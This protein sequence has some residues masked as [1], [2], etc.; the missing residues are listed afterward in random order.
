MVVVTELKNSLWG[1][2]LEAG[3]GKTFELKNDRP[4]VISMA[5]LDTTAT[6]ATSGDVKASA[7]AGPVFKVALNVRRKLERCAVSSFAVLFKR[8][9]GYPIQVT[10]KQLDEVPRINTACGSPLG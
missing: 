8:L 3:K 6:P 7:G 10:A 5:A 2:V 9:Q 4:I 1:L